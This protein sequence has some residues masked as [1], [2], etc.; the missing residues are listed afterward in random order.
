MPF[1][2]PADARNAVVL[3]LAA[4]TAE[5]GP[6]TWRQR[7]IADETTRWVLL[8]W[9]SG[10]ASVAHRHPHASETFLVLEGRL[11]ARIGDG[12]EV[13]AGPGS[14]LFAPRDAIHALR[15]V[16][17]ERLLL[18]ASVAPNEDVPDETID[19]PDR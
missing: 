9:D 6:G 10:T 14:L 3:D 11:A 18:I 15:V 16:G 1:V 17:D 2:D 12:P 19:E 5:A 4:L 13:E 8:A 7:L